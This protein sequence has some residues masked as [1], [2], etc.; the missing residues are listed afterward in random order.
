MTYLQR[1]V[2]IRIPMTATSTSEKTS[3][4]KRNRTEHDERETD[5]P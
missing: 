1:S 4:E 2:G 3:D 5:A